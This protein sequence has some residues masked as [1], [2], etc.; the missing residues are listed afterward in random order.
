MIALKI[1]SCRYLRLSASLALRKTTLQ[2]KL[3][4]A[5]ADV[6]AVRWRLF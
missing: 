4:K 3:S 5:L 6:L 2:A 1:L